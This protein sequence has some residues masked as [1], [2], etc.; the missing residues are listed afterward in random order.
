MQRSEDERRTAPTWRIGEGLE[1]GFPSDRRAPHLSLAGQSLTRSS[2]SATAR[3]R[4]NL[5]D[6]GTAAAVVV[7][8]AV[9]VG[10]GLLLALAESGDP[11]NCTPGGCDNN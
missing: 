8:L 3:A 9:L 6:G 5:S 4:N 1:F 7:G 2:D 11:D 10:G